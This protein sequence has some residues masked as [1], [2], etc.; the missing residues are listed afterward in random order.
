MSDQSSCSPIGQSVDTFSPTHNKYFLLDVILIER[1]KCHAAIIYMDQ[2]QNIF[3]TTPSSIIN[4]PTLSNQ[5]KTW[6]IPTTNL[7][8]PNSPNL[9]LIRIDFSNIPNQGGTN[10]TVATDKERLLKQLD[11]FMAY[12]NSI[13]GIFKNN[14]QIR[15][16][17]IEEVEKKGW[18]YSKHVPWNMV[19]IISNAEKSKKTFTLK[20]SFQISSNDSQIDEDQRSNTPN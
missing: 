17:I 12:Q 19:K 4:I 18:N 20:A 3:I 15:N 10:D 14:P 16:R 1:G 6:F 8:K 13:Q 11:E 5:P 2:N 9:S 7:T